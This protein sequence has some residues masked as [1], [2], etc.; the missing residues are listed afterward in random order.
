MRN[1]IAACALLALSSASLAQSSTA[2]AVKKSDQGIC[3]QRGSATYK[4]TKHFEPYDSMDACLASGGRVARNAAA[5]GDGAD[6][7]GASWLT[8]I[9][10]KA[11]VIIGMLVIVGGAFFLSRRS[12]ARTPPAAAQDD[13]ERKRWEGNRRE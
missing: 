8:G 2:P 12:G 11:V 5:D 1:L 9:G 10:M 6:K 13:L 3:H 4:R 7:P